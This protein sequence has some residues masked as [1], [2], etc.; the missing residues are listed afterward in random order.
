MAG[1]RPS[2][3]DY[4]NSML[5][6]QMWR[7]GASPLPGLADV[8]VPPGAPLFGIAVDW[9]TQR[10]ADLQQPSSRLAGLTKLSLVSIPHPSLAAVLHE[11][12][13]RLPRLADLSISRMHEFDRAKVQSRGDVPAEFKAASYDALHV[14]ASRRPPALT[15]LELHKWALSNLPAGFA[16]CLQGKVDVLQLAGCSAARAVASC[17]CSECSAQRLAVVHSLQACRS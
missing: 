7:G 16:P 9:G 15:H 17:R 2:Q 6:A 14:L 8:A 11:L 3:L 5:Y 4:S 10:A 1:L 12:L 13:P